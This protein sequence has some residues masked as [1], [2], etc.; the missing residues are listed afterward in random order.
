MR[1]N[2]KK[3]ANEIVQEG[4]RGQYEPTTADIALRYALSEPQT[5]D[6]KRHAKK[7]AAELGVLWSWDPKF[8]RFRACPHNDD[9]SCKRMLG[10]VYESWANAGHTAVYNVEGAYKQGYLDEQVRDGVK[11]TT[12][13]FARNI[14]QLGASI[15]YRKASAAA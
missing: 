12:T 15:R 10:Y 3:Y 6:V 8:K 7:I 1:K 9:E 2:L 4:I 11:D 13:Y 5:A 14:E